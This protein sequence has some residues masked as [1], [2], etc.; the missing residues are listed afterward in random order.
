MRAAKALTSLRICADSPSPSLLAVKYRKL[1]H[2]PIYIVLVFK[3]DSAKPKWSRQWPYLLIC[4][5]EKHAFAI[6]LLFSKNKIILKT[7][8][9]PQ[10]QL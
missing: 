10:H 2:G 1:M 4:L 5:V 9:A 3:A 7:E 8:L 6:E